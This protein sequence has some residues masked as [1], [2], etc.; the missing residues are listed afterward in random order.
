ME[1][2]RVGV[3]SGCGDHLPVEPAHPQRV[4][5]AE[6]VVVAEALGALV[7]DR[8]DQRLLVPVVDERRLAFRNARPAGVFRL[9]RGVAAHVIGMA[10]RIDE[11]RELFSR[12]DAFEERQRLRYVGARSEEHTSELQSQSNLVCRL[13]LEKKKTASATY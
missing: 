2:H 4:A 12:K 5:I 1:H 9:D 7:G 11:A 13:L 8:E 3:V 10:M 6:A